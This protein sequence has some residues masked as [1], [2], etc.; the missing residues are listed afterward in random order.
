[1]AQG[2]QRMGL[3]ACTEADQYLVA[4]YSPLPLLSPPSSLSCLR[5]PHAVP[6]AGLTGRGQVQVHAGCTLLRS[7]SGESQVAPM[8]L[9]SG[10]KRSSPSSSVRILAM[11][12]CK[13]T[14]HA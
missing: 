5:G 7:C 10:M 14:R 1:M 11:A 8:S 12:L 4:K 3:G 6:Q 2:H 9:G 13:H